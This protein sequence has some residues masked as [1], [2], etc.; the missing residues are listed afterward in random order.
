MCG[1]LE[2]TSKVTDLMITKKLIISFNK[3]NSWNQVG[4]LSTDSPFFMLREVRF[5]NYVE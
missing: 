4:L 5:F 3:M 1:S 2:T